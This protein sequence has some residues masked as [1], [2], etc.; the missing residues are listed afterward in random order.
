VSKNRLRSKCFLLVWEVPTPAAGPSQTKAAGSEGPG[1]K[2]DR[3][4]V[5]QEGE[6]RAGPSPER[7]AENK[8]RCQTGPEKRRCR[9]RLFSEP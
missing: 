4:G 1:P 7:L 9:L 6:H 3:A 2:G 8:P 5:S